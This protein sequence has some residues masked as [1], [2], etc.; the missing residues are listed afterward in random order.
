M[1]RFARASLL[2]GSALAL[3]A[4]GLVLGLPSSDDVKNDFGDAATGADAPNPKDGAL[5]DANPGDGGG[6]D[7]AD[8]GCVADLTKDPLNCG[9]CGRSC[10]G[11]ACTDGKCAPKLLATGGQPENVRVANGYVYFTDF[12]NDTVKRVKTDGTGT[13]TIATA[14][15]GISGPW[16]VVVDPTGTTIYIAS[17]YGGKVHKCPVAGCG[18][19]ATVVDGNASRPAL[20]ELTAT[21]LYYLDVYNDRVYENGFDGGARVERATTDTSY[22]AGLL[23]GFTIDGTHAYWSE[24]YNGTDNVKR[25]PLDGGATQSIVAA[26]PRYPTSLRID[27]TKIWF[28]GRGLGDNGGTIS[29]K[30]VTGSGNLDTFATGLNNPVGLYMDSTHVYWLDEGSVTASTDGTV[31][32]GRVLRCPRSGCGVPEELAKG[33]T[34]PVS[35]DSDGVDLFWVDYSGGGKLYKLAK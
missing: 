16:G 19:P 25:A 31:T 34:N 28:V 4:C 20:L 11:E 7:A 23:S 6:P 29:S 27:G 18:T 26:G 17:A 22:N 30:S 1:R 3:S 13:Q 9:R 10:Y 12:K 35:L 33:Q 14:T 5:P 8:A 21:K 2:A 24:P 15:N 32:D